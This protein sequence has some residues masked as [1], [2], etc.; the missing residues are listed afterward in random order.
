MI[1]INWDVQS[2]YN[3]FHSL[4]QQ[5]VNVKLPEIQQNR[6]TKSKSF[7][8]PYWNQ[9]LQDQ[10]NTVFETGKTCIRFRGPSQ[11]KMY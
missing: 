3:E 10:W 4:I 6:N 2:A 8:K 11:H 7:Y 5:E 9:T 1:Y